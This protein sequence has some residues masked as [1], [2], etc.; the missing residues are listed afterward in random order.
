MSSIDPSALEPY[1]EVMGLPAVVE[2]LDVFLGTTQDLVDALYSTV[3]CGDAKIFTR[4]AH[5]LKSNSAIFGAQALSNMCL[6]LEAAGKSANLPDLLP[7]ID[8]LKAE[9]EQVCRE[10]T[11]LREQLA[12]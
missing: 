1:C 8:R 4:S 7:K 11:Q 12:T 3:S 9:Y 5:T 6:E 2:L 10:L